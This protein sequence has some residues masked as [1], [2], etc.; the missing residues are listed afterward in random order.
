MSEI[1]NLC[2]GDLPTTITSTSAS[3][4]STWR[5]EAYTTTSVTYGVIKFSNT[6]K[7]HNFSGCIPNTDIYMKE[8]IY[9]NPATIVLW[10]DGTKT[11]SKCKSPDIYSRETGLALC[12]LKKIYGASTMRKILEDWTP[13][14]PMFVSQKITLKDVMKNNK[15]R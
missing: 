11:V 6:K 14:A 4:P 15:M 5:D 2:V 8:V 7:K 10:S 9:S 3:I 1:K 12:M 13:D